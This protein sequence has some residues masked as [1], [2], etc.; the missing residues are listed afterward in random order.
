VSDDDEEDAKRRVCVTKAHLADFLMRNFDLN[1]YSRG[2]LNLAPG[3][4]VKRVYGM[5]DTFFIH[6]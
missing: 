3:K 2:A 6:G 4:T 5:I 1:D